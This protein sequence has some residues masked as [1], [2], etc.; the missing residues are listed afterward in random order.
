M[1][2]KLKSGSGPR[3]LGEKSIAFRSAAMLLTT[4]ACSSEESLTEPSVVTPE[5]RVAKTYTAVDLGTL[6]GQLSVA[7]DIN[8]AGQVVGISRSAD[9]TNR[10]FLWENGVMTALGTLP[11]GISSDIATGI[12]PGGQVVG[13][14]PGSDVD[15]QRAFLW[16]NGA[17]ITLGALDGGTYTDARDINPAGRVVGMSYASGGPFRAFL[18]DQGTMTSL[19][20]LPGDI[21]SFATA[22]NPAGEIVGYSV[23]EDGRTSAFLWRNGVMTDLGTLG[24]NSA[25]SGI[26]SQGQIV[27]NSET[28][29]GSA[30]AFLWEKGAMTDLGDFT[31]F[32]INAAGQIAGHKFVPE[33]QTNHAVVW[34]NG[35]LTDLGTLGGS[36][37]FA[38][39]IDARGRVV[40]MSY[41]TAGEPHATLWVRRVT[42]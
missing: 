28:P 9:G 31:P 42:K 21:S 41:T 5:M 3:R 24:G 15:D 32:D 22:I 19:G 20:T 2:I 36:F 25:A 29:D 34:T 18:W 17:M 10:A 1:S 14:I 8:S 6:G 27:G 37:S 35:V 40:G 38:S 23:G 11:G 7:N 26:N 39:A 4:L 13:N 30:H 12:N 16:E 33:V